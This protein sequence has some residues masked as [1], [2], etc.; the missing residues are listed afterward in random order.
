MVREWKF[1]WRCSLN[2]TEP[3]RGSNLLVALS[4]RGEESV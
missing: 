1:V 2:R 4:K 3:A